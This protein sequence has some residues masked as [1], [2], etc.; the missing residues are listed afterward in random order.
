MLCW[1]LQLLLD[2]VFGYC[3]VL[4]FACMI[5]VDLCQVCLV[6]FVLAMAYALV[7]VHHG[8]LVVMT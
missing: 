5:L 6:H 3:A 8:C 2:M 1:F 7:L 4:V